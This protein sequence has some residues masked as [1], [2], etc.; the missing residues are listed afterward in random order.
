[1]KKYE[2]SSNYLSHL[3]RL[4]SIM[5]TSATHAGHRSSNSSL[6]SSRRHQLPERNDA[7]LKSS[8]REKF[9]DKENKWLEYKENL[10]IANSIINKP[11][12]VNFQSAEENFKRHLRIRK[13]RTLFPPKT[14]KV[15]EIQVVDL[16]W[17]N[18]VKNHSEIFEIKGDDVDS[19][20]ATV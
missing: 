18:H 6:C 2:D 15:K 14:Q 8:L 7:R 19:V 16:I 9:H 17:R 3:K 1:M 10:R 5:N 13:L 20:R 11:G 12:V 4:A